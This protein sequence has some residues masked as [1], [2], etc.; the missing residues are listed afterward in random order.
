MVDVLLIWWPKSISTKPPYQTYQWQ[1]DKEIVDD[2][3][4]AVLLESSF[5][6]S[7]PLGA[8]CFDNDFFC[9]CHKE[10]YWIFFF[11]GHDHK[12]KL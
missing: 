6:W 3:F 2:L 9:H 8:L 5:S 4:I 12:K 1:F 10:A 7:Q 11:V